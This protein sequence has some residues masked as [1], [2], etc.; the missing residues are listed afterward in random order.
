MSKVELAVNG[1]AVG[2]NR[3]GFKLISEK[4]DS[5]LVKDIPRVESDK[6]RIETEEAGVE[7]DGVEM[8]SKE[9]EPVSNRL[10]VDIKE[11]GARGNVP[12]M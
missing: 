6:L 7:S 8:A 12:E 1:L 5:E 4:Q 3:L 2:N 9:L 11:L 10:T